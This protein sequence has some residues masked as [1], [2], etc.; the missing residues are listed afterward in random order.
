M[1]VAGRRTG[2]D[3]K[4]RRELVMHRGPIRQAVSG[5]LT[6]F[7]IFAGLGTAFAETAIYTYDAAHR[8]I[9]VNKNSS[10]TEYQYDAVGNLLGRLQRYSVT[11]SPAS[12]NFSSVAVGSS[13]TQTFTIT[14]AGSSAI[15]LGTVNVTGAD[16][17]SFSV[18]NGCSGVLAPAASCSVQV[19]FVPTAVNAQSGTIALSFS[20][21][22]SLRLDIPVTGSGYFRN[23]RIARATPA[24]F[25][26][27]QAAYDAAVSGEVIQLQAV[28]FME[29]D[30]L[31]RDIAVTV[32]GG[33]DDSF[34]TNNGGLSF[35]RGSIRTAGGSA[36]MKNIRVIQ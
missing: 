12:S 34:I 22:D 4:L 24:Y 14:N 35:L 23:V 8:L 26:T 36:T 2:M 7:L 29:T 6:L 18:T 30:L 28:T 27:L 19:S 5:L 3:L 13:S 11:A 9:Q 20:V 31:N 25:D 10:I 17:S 15:T 1:C 21:P 16:A 32:E 33:Y